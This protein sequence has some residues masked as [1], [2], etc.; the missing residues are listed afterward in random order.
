MFKDYKEPKLQY[1]NNI[2][3]KS[4]QHFKENYTNYYTNINKSRILNWKDSLSS[5]VLTY[6]NI[7]ITCIY[8]QADLFHMF[9]DNDSLNYNDITMYKELVDTLIKVK[10]IKNKNGILSF[11]KPK[12]NI[13]LLK[14]SKNP[15]KPKTENVTN[16]QQ[17]Q[18]QYEE[19]IID[20]FICVF[21]NKLVKSNSNTILTELKK[22]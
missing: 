13:N 11:R 20:A 10:L 1:H 22:V 17:K 3:K 4:L 5:C 12:N 8:Q 14:Y 9:N 21:S 7:D 18:I 19:D 2:F 6:D 15:N 16:I